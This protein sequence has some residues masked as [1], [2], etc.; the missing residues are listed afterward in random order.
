MKVFHGSDTIVDKPL[1]LQ[2]NRP[3]DFGG[4]FYVTTS[5]KQAAAWAVKVS[6][7]NAVNQRCV[8]IY[9]F[10]L[11]KA[12]ENLNVKIFEKADEEWLDFICANRQGKMVDGYD[13]IVGPVADDKV[14]RV[15]V[16]YE[17]KDI[18]KETALKKLKTEKLCNQVLFHTAAALKYLKY[19]NTEMITE[20]E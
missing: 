15:V 7:R 10:D 13:I 18:E 9:D 14:Y 17:N 12:K 6:Y 2:A 5:K 11:E 3:L 4:G 8:N 16:E 19:I 20:N 1:I